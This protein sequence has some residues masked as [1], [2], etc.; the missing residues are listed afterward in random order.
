MKPKIWWR[1]AFCGVMLALGL[2]ST[3]QAADGDPAP[4][5]SSQ[6][7]SMN[8]V[9]QQRLQRDAVCTKC[10]DESETKPIL[11]LYQRPHGAVGD[12]NAPGC[13]SC[14]GD[15]ADHV[16]GSKED[17]EHRPRPDMIFGSKLINGFEPN[18]PQEQSEVCLGCHKSGL[19]MRWPGSQHESNDLACT[20][21]HV[22]HR[23]ADPMLTKT[24]QPG[25]CEGCHQEKRAE[26]KEISA[27]PIEAGKMACSDCHNPHGSPGP[28]LLAKN[29]VTETCFQCHADKR[30]PFLWEHEPVTED[31][32][33]CHNPHGSNITPLLKSRPPFLCD[34]CHDG[35]HASG[36]PYGTAVGGIQGGGVAAGG[37]PS[38][39][40][41]SRACMNCHVMIHGSNSPAGAYLHR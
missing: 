40:A 12:P 1:V 23:P 9:A 2:T 4:R 37:N 15:S 38:S 39:T 41:V 13:R 16:A 33:N 29:T 27:H 14:H 11:A 30:G 10:H 8:P 28:K 31:C 35:P 20:S 17:S 6:A 21:C 34:E 5:A 22:N 7:A 25:V 19:R 3:A 18:T 32:T 26:V 36:S 24:E